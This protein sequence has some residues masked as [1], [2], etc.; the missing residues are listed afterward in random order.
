MRIQHYLAKCAVASRRKAEQIVREGRV[1]VNG[2]II[3]APGTIIA[4]NDIITVNGVIVK[5]EKQKVY[6]MLNKPKGYVST[7]R[8]QFGRQTVLDLIKESE[9]HKF[10]LYPVGR[11]DY[12]TSGLIIL[13]NDGDFTHRVTH[14]SYNIN[15]KYIADVKGI[16]DEEDILNFSKGIDIGGYITSPAELKIIKRLSSNA[17]VS[18]IIHEGRNRQVRRM[19]ESIGHSVL[20]LKRVSIGKLSLGKLREGEWRRLG[21]EE[22]KLIL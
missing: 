5:P 15:K 1:A 3:T 20:D 19:F 6:I 22:I 12:D 8:D 21:D 13:T 14:P 11:L 10:R 7:A 9:I 17:R 2:E 16:P 4:T 18:V